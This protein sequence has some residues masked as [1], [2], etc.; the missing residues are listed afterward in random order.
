MA[1]LCAHAY[2]NHDVDV[3]DR[4]PSMTL[5][6][7]FVLCLGFDLVVLGLERGGLSGARKNRNP[8]PKKL[9]RTLPRAHAPNATGSA[10]TAAGA[11]GA[12]G[13]PGAPGAAAKTA[14]A[15]AAG[16]GAGGAAA[17]AHM[18]LHGALRTYRAHANKHLNT[19]T[20]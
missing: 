19:R 14:T 9:P 18:P 6:R 17:A 3:S 11:A 13:A 7:A 20:N 5:L 16:A 8:G 12:A 4:N 15:A 10:A 2:L 1:F